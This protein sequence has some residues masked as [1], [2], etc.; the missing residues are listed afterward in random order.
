RQMIHWLG[1][2]IKNRELG[3]RAWG[4]EWLKGDER[5]GYTTVHFT[6]LDFDPVAVIRGVSVHS[7]KR[8]AELG[9]IEGVVTKY[10]GPQ[11]ATVDLGQ[12]IT[13]RFTPLERITRDDQGKRVKVYASFGYDG[14]V[15]W[16]PLLLHEDRPQPT[17]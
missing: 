15:G 5:Q 1:V 16:D 8:L 4:Y 17:I 2:C 14:I 11:Q 10:R 6:E 12:G 3:H 7:R 13:L 9:R